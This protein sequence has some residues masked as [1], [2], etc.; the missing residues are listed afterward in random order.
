MEVLMNLNVN[1]SG[2]RQTDT[3]PLLNGSYKESG[4]M[5]FFITFSNDE[6]QLNE[7][8]ITY[9]AK[10]EA[11]IKVNDKNVKWNIDIS[12]DINITYGETTNMN[13]SYSESGKINDGTYN[14][15]TNY[16]TNIILFNLTM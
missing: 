5:K 1:F 12:V 14:Y 3:S 2:Y 9:K 7:I 11:D 16:S 4:T 10:S 6:L 13:I 15:S 8:K